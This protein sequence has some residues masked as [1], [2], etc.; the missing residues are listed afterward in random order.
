MVCFLAYTLEMALRQAMRQHEGLIQGPIL[1][2]HAY[3]ELVAQPLASGESHVV[4][5]VNCINISVG[6]SPTAP[7]A[8]QVV[9]SSY[10]PYVLVT[11]QPND[12]WIQGILVETNTGAQWTLP[13]HEILAGLNG[14]PFF[15]AGV[16]NGWAYYQTTT[17]GSANGLVQGAINLATG[18]TEPAPSL[19]FQHYDC[20]GPV[21]RGPDGTLYAA[22]ES[23]PSSVD[24]YRFPNDN[25]PFNS[26]LIAENLPVDLGGY[27]FAELTI[28]PNGTIWVPR[29]GGTLTAN[30]GSMSIRV[31][32]AVS[33]PPKSKVLLTG[34]GYVISLGNPPSADD[35]SPVQVTVT[36]TDGTKTITVGAAPDVLN[37]FGTIPYLSPG[38][39]SQVVFFP[40]PNGLWQ[41]VTVSRGG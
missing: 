4:A 16:Y 41:I 10:S 23:G 1:D 3:R 35:E 18:A 37:D 9:D 34:V 12:K 36:T 5:K 38:P 24:L 15:Y 14:F 33:A 20:G 17:T 19:P 30:A 26:T 39:D 25:D 21:Y 29:P 6:N 11:C 31:A 2:E 7:P 8:V 32:P 13:V 40:A 22:K 28:D 27:C